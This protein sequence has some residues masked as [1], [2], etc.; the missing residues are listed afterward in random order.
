MKLEHCEVHDSCTIVDGQHTERRPAP[1]PKG[2]VK[3]VDYDAFSRSVVTKIEELVRKIHQAGE[4]VAGRQSVLEAK[5]TKAVAEMQKSVDATVEKVSK[6]SEVA[7]KKKSTKAANEEAMP[8]RVK[9]LF[10]ADGKRKAELDGL[11]DEVTK[12]AELVDVEAK[13][14]RAA[15]RQLMEM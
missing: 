6:L 11:R 4:E 14:R 7:D 10:E 13:G 3:E 8:G 12:L 9:A 15:I 2:F 5:L 1:M